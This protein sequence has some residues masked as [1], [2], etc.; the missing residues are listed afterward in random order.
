MQNNA[1]SDAQ[2]MGP[3]VSAPPYA[4]PKRMS[5]K[6]IVILVISLVLGA[7]LLIGLFIGGIIAVVNSV[8]KNAMETEEY[9]LAYEYLVNSRTYQR[10]ADE[11]TTVRFNSVSYR[12]GSSSEEGDVTVEMGFMVEGGAYTVILHENDDGWY[13]CQDCT[14]FE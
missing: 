1:F 13:V 11:K 12:Y 10:I 6:K 3:T 8:L 14:A 5:E 4:P 2:N 9:L 7:V